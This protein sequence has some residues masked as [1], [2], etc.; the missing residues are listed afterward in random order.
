[1]ERNGT[2]DWS[3]ADSIAGAIVAAQVA[4]VVVIVV[5]RLAP[6]RIARFVHVV[7]FLAH[8]HFD[9]SLVNATVRLGHVNRLAPLDKERNY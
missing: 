6:V 9:G 8:G 2:N 1:M 7:N 4:A 3:N 5:T